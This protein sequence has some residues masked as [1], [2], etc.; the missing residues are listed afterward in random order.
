MMR[1]AAKT[2]R[3]SVME[4][5]SKEACIAEERKIL[6]CMHAFQQQ[7]RIKDDLFIVTLIYLKRLYL[8]LK[9][10][11]KQLLES[12]ESQVRDTLP[13]TVCDPLIQESQE[14]TKRSN[15]QTKITENNFSGH[16]QIGSEKVDEPSHDG[17]DFGQYYPSKSTSSQQDFSLLEQSSSCQSTASFQTITERSDNS[18]TG[19]M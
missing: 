11:I 10:K 5:T 18:S 7:F 19:S 1:N 3:A 12:R 17:D 14:K 6:K 13:L 15:D 9:S 2:T 4:T 8:K 16:L